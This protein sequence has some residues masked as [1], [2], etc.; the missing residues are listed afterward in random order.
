MPIAKESS[1]CKLPGRGS[2]SIEVYEVFGYQQKLYCQNLSLISKLFL[3]HKGV[4]FDVS[5]FKYYVLTEND[6][7]GRH[8]AAYFSKEISR[9]TEY[10]LA[11]IMVLPPY[12][13]R[14]YGQFLISLSYYFSKT[15]GRICTPEIP[16]SD[17]GK[18]SYKSYWTQTILETILK[19]KGNLHIKDISRLT[20]IK[21]DD[22]NFTLNELSLIKYWKGQQVIQNINL[23]EIEYFL[24]RKRCYGRGRIVFDACFVL[25]ENMQQLVFE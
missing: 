1:T 12:Q 5:K 18:I 19:Y 25:D 8:M 16:L 9:T 11:C 20:G 24:R 13:R 22:I 6:E 7:N 4:F 15:E 10:N 2:S 23:K 21:V 14:G 17:L 3:D